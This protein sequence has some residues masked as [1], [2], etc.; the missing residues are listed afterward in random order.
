MNKVEL[1]FI[2]TD[3]PYHL[4][5]TTLGLFFLKNFLGKLFFVKFVIFVRGYVLTT[6]CV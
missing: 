4:S 3:W 1:K 5:I 2:S 6:V